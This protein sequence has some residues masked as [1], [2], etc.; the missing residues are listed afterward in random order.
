M[1]TLGKSWS[2]AQCG[3]EAAYLRHH[4]RGE[5][6]CYSCMQANSRV[7]ADRTG[8]D[9]R[10]PSI[11]DPRQVR[12]GLPAPK[13]YVYRAP[14]DPWGRRGFRFEANVRQRLT[15]DKTRSRAA[16]RARA[17]PEQGLAERATSVQH[18]PIGKRSR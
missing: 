1:S 18:V 3:T 10:G 5:R 17:N 15:R 14:L 16:A 9:Y 7:H 13:P 11:P 6:A 4:R 8:G 2:E 12:N